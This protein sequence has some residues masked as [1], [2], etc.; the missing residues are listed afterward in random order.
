MGALKFE[1][2]TEE[3]DQRGM[4]RGLAQGREEGIEKGI[5]QGIEQGCAA[6]RSILASILVRRF[7]RVP[8]GA[9]QR[10][11][12]ASIA[13]LEQWIRRAMEVDDADA[14]FAPQPAAPA[15]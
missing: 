8:G 10:I 15:G 5:E 13:E 7:G 2:W 14:V 9:Q 3:L 12:A 6:L 4:Q 1:T 11:D